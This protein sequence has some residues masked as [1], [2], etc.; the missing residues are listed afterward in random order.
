[1]SCAAAP[2]CF[3]AYIQIRSVVMRETDIRIRVLM[4]P[5][6]RRSPCRYA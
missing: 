2:V 6:F 1:M 5:R 4:G 3:C